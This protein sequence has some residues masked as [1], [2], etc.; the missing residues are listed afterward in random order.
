MAQIMYE[1]GDLKITWL[2]HDGFKFE[3]GKETLVIDP[4]KLSHEA[5]A[6]YL[7]LTHEHFDH[8]NAEDIGKVVKSGS[9][10][11]VA[12]PASK[13]E[14][15]KVKSKPKEIKYVKPGDKVKLGSFEV[16][17]VPAYNTNKYA[18]PG[19]HF[20]PKEDQK[21]GYI[22][23][24]S[25]G[26]SVYHT[27]DSDFIPEMKGLKPDIALVP[28]SGTYVM[29][30]DEAVEAVASINPKVAIPMH[31]AS[32]VGT[33]D[34]AQRFKEKVKTEVVILEKE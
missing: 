23:K 12:I 7:L 9:T 13:E 26:I 8:S 18:A 16:Q 22:I 21:V 25:G 32:I 30:S 10:V 2:G 17:A 34:D 27:G 28:V 6:D 19:R 33:K 3:S 20:H 5:K 14:L 24:T 29:T 15:S 11:V 1:K 4:F 31:Y